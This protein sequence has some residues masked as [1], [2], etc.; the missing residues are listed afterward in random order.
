MGTKSAFN[1]TISLPERSLDDVKSYI[2]YITFDISRYGKFTH[3]ISFESPVTEKMA[4]SEVERWLANDASSEYYNYIKEDLFHDSYE[5]YGKNPKR[6]DFIGG[7]YF[8]E[9][10]KYIS[11]NHVK[12]SCGS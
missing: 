4:I 5:D 9:E 1:Y 10:I 11:R 8:L 7:C 6:F 3:T 2:K 12:T